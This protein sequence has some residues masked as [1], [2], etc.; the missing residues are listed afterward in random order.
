MCHPLL[1]VCAK[2][3]DQLRSSTRFFRSEGGSWMGKTSGMWSQWLSLAD[4]II[5][6]NCSKDA[7]AMMSSYSISSPAKIGLQAKYPLPLPPIWSCCIDIKWWVDKFFL[8]PPRLS[9]LQKIIFCIFL[10]A[11]DWSIDPLIESNDN[12]RLNIWW[13]SAMVKFRKRHFIY[14]YPYVIEF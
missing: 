2:I 7:A 4:K 8:L 10:Q 1:D 5:L 12:D 14:Y 3:L 11:M 9:I 6:V 13:W